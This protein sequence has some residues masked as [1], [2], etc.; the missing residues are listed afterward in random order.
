MSPLRADARLLAGLLLFAAG[1]SALAASADR[2]QP[3]DVSART[4]DATLA[5]GDSI[6]SGEV[7]ITQG[8]LEIR[9]DKATLTRTAG[10]LSRVV[11]EGE[12]ASLK[13]I[14]DQ[15]QPVSVR[16]RKVTY[17]P[18]SNEVLLEGEVQVDRPEGM[19][20]GEVI[21]YD[22]ANGRLN[23]RGEGAND[24]IRMSFQPRPNG[25]A[26]ATPTDGG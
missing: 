8:S 9:A 14:D 4:G 24:R 19:L 23:A 21:T 16:A 15:G 25:T 20:Q 13:Q 17:T 6:L 5:D 7:V 11:F 26:P 1:G 10:E 22:M 12:P 2:Q 3:V 18:T